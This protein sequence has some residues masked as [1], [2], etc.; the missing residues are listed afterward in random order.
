[1]QVCDVSTKTPAWPY[2]SIHVLKGS[3]FSFKWARWKTGIRPESDQRWQPM[4]ASAERCA[5]SGGESP[6]QNTKVQLGRLPHY[7]VCVSMAIFQFFFFIPAGTKQTSSLYKALVLYTCKNVNIFKKQIFLL[8][9]MQTCYVF[10]PLCKKYNESI[11]VSFKLWHQDEHCN[12][13]M[14]KM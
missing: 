5:L 9:S 8:F 6:H 3:S 2:V 1:M 12:C 13:A 7:T 4:A 10:A 14:V 11:I